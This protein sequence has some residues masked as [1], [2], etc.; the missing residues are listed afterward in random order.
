[1]LTYQIIHILLINTLYDLRAEHL[2]DFLFETPSTV[3]ITS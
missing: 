3:E 1:M 2:N